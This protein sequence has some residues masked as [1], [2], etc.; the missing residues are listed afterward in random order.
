MTKTTAVAPQDLRV[1]M[2]VKFGKDDFRTITDIYER[3][4]G[5]TW[6]KVSGGNGFNDFAVKSRQ[7]R[8]AA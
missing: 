8:V 3:W 1:G 4:P 2:S 7:W 6:V 5:H